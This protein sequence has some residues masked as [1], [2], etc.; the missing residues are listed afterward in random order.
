MPRLTHVINLPASPQDVASQLVCKRCR[1]YIRRA[2]E[3]GLDVAAVGPEY[4][5]TFY[6][7]LERNRA[8]HGARPT[9][10]LADLQRI[11]DL[12]PDRV[13]LF[14]CNWRD[15]MIAGALVFELNPRVAYLFYLCHEDQFAALRA[16]TVVTLRVAQ[17]YSGRGVRYLDMGPTSFDDLQMNE[18]LA[19]F[20]EEMGAV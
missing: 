12:T 11:F 20:K 10:G 8:K 5:P 16:A 13:R 6:R 7:V 2:L 1:N 3:Q 18:G 17:H 9:H 19:R 15:E 4:L 14:A